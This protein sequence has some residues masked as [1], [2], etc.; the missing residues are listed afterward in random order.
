M[1]IIYTI[2]KWIKNKK[3]DYRGHGSTL[4]GGAGSEAFPDWPFGTRS[5]VDCHR[6]FYADGS[7]VIPNHYLFEAIK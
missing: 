2:K 5:C 3:C 6:Y 4:S 1:I 7:Y